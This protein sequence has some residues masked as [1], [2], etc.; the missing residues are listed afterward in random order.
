MLLA[1]CAAFH[2][3][4]EVGSP[5]LAVYASDATLPVFE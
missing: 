3:Y 2:S 1:H 5:S 4:A